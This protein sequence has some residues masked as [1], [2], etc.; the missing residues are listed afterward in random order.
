MIELRSWNDYLDAL[1]DRCTVLLPLVAAD[2]GQIEMGPEERRKRR[3]MVDDLD[4]A[5][6][7]YEQRTRTSFRDNRVITQ[8]GVAMVDSG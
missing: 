6:G 5:I 1:T 8:E 2:K 4:G 7:E 3:A